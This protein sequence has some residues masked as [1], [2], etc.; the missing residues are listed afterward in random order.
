[1]ITKTD[2]YIQHYFTLFEK[3]RPHRDFTPLEIPL[4]I[5]RQG[6]THK[7]SCDR[8]ETQTLH[9]DG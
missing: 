3:M 2:D 9:M 6:Y 1:M 8:K 7:Q 5:F 4:K